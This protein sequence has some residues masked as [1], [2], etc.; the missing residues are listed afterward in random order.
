MKPPYPSEILK[1]RFSSIYQGE[2]REWL[3][4]A[5]TYDIHNVSNE[6]DAVLQ[7]ESDIDPLLAGKISP[8]VDGSDLKFFEQGEGL[9]GR[10]LQTASISAADDLMVNCRFFTLDEAQSLDEVSNRMD[11]DE[12]DREA[13]ISSI[14]DRVVAFEAKVEKDSHNLVGLE[15]NSGVAVLG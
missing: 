15:M 1:I 2:M 14:L 12:R 10:K 8:S 7:L 9:A 13:A 11:I 3:F 5:F 4:R 6:Y